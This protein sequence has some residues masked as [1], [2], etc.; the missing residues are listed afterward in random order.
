MAAGQSLPARVARRRRRSSVKSPTFRSRKDGIAR[1]RRTNASA[2]AVSSE[3]ANGGQIIVAARFQAFNALVQCGQRTKYQYGRF[4]PL[5]ALL[6]EWTA[7]LYCW[8]AC[9]QGY[10]VPLLLCCPLHTLF[11]IVTYN[12]GMPQ[13]FKPA[14]DVTGV[15]VVIFNNQALPHDSAKPPEQTGVTSKIH[16]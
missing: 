4:C 5:A 6:P 10:D 9:G 15:F 12:G 7:R 13:P 16:D 1:E 11:A 8:A 14:G 2:R 3:K